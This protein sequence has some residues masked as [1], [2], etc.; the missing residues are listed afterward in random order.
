MD[1]KVVLEDQDSSLHCV[2]CNNWLNLKMIPYNEI[3]NG[4][5]LEFDSLPSLFCEKCRTS[6]IPWQARLLIESAEEQC[7]SRKSDGKF[8]SKFNDIKKEFQYCKSVK[9]DYDWTDYY[10]LPG[11]WRAWD[12]GA[13]TPVFF[14]KK[15]L[16]KYYMDPDYQI[17]QFSDTYGSLY[18]KNEFM[19]SFGVNRNGKLFVWLYQLDKLPLIEQK[20]FSSFNLQSDHD[21][22]S[23][24]Y[25]STIEAEFGTLSKEQYLLELRSKVISKFK[26]TSNLKLY[27]EIE[28]FDKIEIN[29]MRP[30]IWDD[31][32]VNDI[33]T[34]LNKICIEC[35]NT[36]SLKL[37]L[38]K[39]TP[40]V[41]RH[42]IRGLKLFEEYLKIKYPKSNYEEI[43]KPFFVLYDIRQCLSH[44]MSSTKRR[45]ILQFCFRRLG[46]KYS[47]D[48]E[49]IYDKL[50]ERI[51]ESYE[52]LSRI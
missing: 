5:R 30:I 33:I 6:F 51:T 39:L 43:M 20:Y 19:I 21:I 16:M 27:N 48:F 44:L 26:N 12:E 31:K 40:D 25:L 14:D 47:H 4:L 42:G 49:I 13:L 17:D 22:A 10:F 41:N 1:S 9:F 50:I 29:L 15:V 24:F 46:I 45:K 8:R 38:K 52:E 37:Q 3:S 18:Y 35:I 36:R 34:T 7:N 11:L 23:E 32:G 2:K 28:N